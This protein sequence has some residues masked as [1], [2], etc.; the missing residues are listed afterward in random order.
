MCQLLT[1]ISVEMEKS[2][3]LMFSSDLAMHALENIKRLNSNNEIFQDDK[4]QTFRRKVK[5]F[6]IMQWFDFTVPSGLKTDRSFHSSVADFASVRS[7][8]Q[9]LRIVC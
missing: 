8:H 5:S 4:S 7:Y 3:R 1:P 2:T 9:K 6:R